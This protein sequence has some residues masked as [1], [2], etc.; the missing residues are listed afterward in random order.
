MGDLGPSYNPG[1]GYTAGASVDSALPGSSGNTSPA[2][3]ASSIDGTYLTAAQV[4]ALEGIKKRAG[5]IPVLTKRGTIA[6]GADTYGG[7]T[8]PGPNLPGTPPGPK[9]PDS[10]HD[11]TDVV[12]S[13]ENMD[14][15]QV[16]Q[17]Q[18]MMLD[19]HL[20]SQSYYGRSGY[21]VVPG[22]IDSGTMAAWKK[23]VT[24]A[25]LSR[26]TVDEVLGDAA[27]EATKAGFVA[28]KIGPKVQLT[29]PEDL[30]AAALAAGEKVLGRRPDPGFVDNLVASY[31]TM[32]ADASQPQADGTFVNQPGDPTAFAEHL[33]RQLY[34]TDTAVHD[35][36]NVGNEIVNR[37]SA[38]AGSNLPTTGTPSG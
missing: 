24:T 27:G 1:T 35:Y 37:L 29:N 2:G 14:P 9:V 19:A 34:P 23:A 18:Q 16:A 22:E 21:S 10:Y 31:H 3:D 12:N 28:P 33:L 30:R 20:Y 36:L 11:Y 8:N 5:V 25:A 17:I 6:A 15:G 32:E 7:G 4:Q 26:R 38:P 13:I